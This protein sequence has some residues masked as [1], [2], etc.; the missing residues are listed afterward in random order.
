MFF[1]TFHVINLPSTRL[2]LP[3]LL[4]PYFL[5]SNPFI[6][7]L[8]SCLI[9]SLG[10]SQL[11]SLAFCVLSVMPNAAVL[12][13]EILE[14]AL[15]EA[16]AETNLLTTSDQFLFDGLWRRRGPLNTLTSLISYLSHCACQMKFLDFL[17][18]SEGNKD[19]NTDHGAGQ[20]T[21]FQLK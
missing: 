13:L 3:T 12:L 11:D 10:S 7:L 4:S 9:F 19:Q 6:M 2:H 1:S 8:S 5:S 14:T 17:Q 15:A 21:A 18:K 20:N 16:L